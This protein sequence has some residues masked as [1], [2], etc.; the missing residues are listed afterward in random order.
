MKQPPEVREFLLKTS[1]LK[2]L[3][4]PL[5]DAVTQGTNGRETLINLEKAN[6]FVVPLDASR[7]WYRYHHLFADL[8]Q[9]Q[10]ELDFGEKKKD[11]LHRKASEWYEIKGFFDEAI[12]HAL[13]GEDW[14]KAIELIRNPAVMARELRSLTLLNWLRR[15]P[16]EQLRTHEGI[17]LNYI[18]ALMTDGQLSAAE[19]CLKYLDTIAGNNTTLQGRIAIARANIAVNIGDI[20]K[21]EEYAVKAHSL[22]PPDDATQVWTQDRSDHAIIGLILATVLMMQG[23]HLEA[24]N[25]LQSSLEFLQ[26]IGASSSTIDPLVMLG[27][28]AFLKGELHKAA[29]LGQ[30]A[31]EAVKGHPK[32]AAG[33]LWLGNIY[34]EWNDLERAISHYEQAAEMLSLQKGPEITGYDIAC[35]KLAL[36]RIAMGD[37]SGATKAMEDADKLLSDGT[38]VT[39]RNRALNTSYH[40]AIA[41]TEGDVESAARWVDD[42][43]KSGA[44]LPDNIPVSIIRLIYA[45]RGRAVEEKEFQAAYERFKPQGLR[46][47][48]MAA[49]IV[50]ALDSLG[51]DNPLIYLAEALTLAKTEGYIRVFVDFGLELKPLLKQAITKGIEPEYAQKLLSITEGEDRRRQIAKAKGVPVPQSSEFLSLRELEVLRS[52][53]EGLSN[54]QIAEKLIV[55]LG[56]VKTHIHNITQKLS[57]RN[58]TGAI[59]R[60]RELKLI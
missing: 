40:A 6:L 33:H 47:M 50:Q 16:E 2:R 60:A 14:A 28:I 13:S 34:Y 23:R 32:T 56:T 4:G 20:T 22:L 58:R 49:R 15:I 38:L 7:E 12:N 48:M 24:E 39:P 1:I 11:E 17:Y 19:N 10:L 59:A 26:K 44:P 55:G 45:Q 42:I 27:T 46:Y 54:R 29:R 43:V 37:I 8:L 25:I 53:A 5:C 31:I 30:D 3:C 18:W 52:A 51:P 21:A 9:H 41:L 36:T 35:F 57:A